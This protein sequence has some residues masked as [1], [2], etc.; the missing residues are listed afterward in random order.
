MSTHHSSRAVRT[1]V[2]AGMIVVQATLPCLVWSLAAAQLGRPTSN[3]STTATAGIVNSM[4]GAVFIRTGSGR[5][6]P[7]KPGDPVGRG[8]VVSTGADGEAILLFADG[9]H[10]N[11]NADSILRVDEYRF[12]VRDVKSN[13]VI[14]TLVWHHWNSCGCQTTFSQ[15]RRHADPLGHPAQRSDC[16]LR[17]MQ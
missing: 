3:S 12:D 15:A 16:W 11:L 2:A 17:K 4:S 6:V 10:V 8:T 9:Q 13:R 7:A 5:E 14:Y 1:L